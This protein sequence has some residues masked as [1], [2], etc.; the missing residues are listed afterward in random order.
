M[1]GLLGVLA[2]EAARNRAARRKWGVWALASRIARWLPGFTVA[3]A[4]AGVLVRAGI[5]FAAG[6]FQTMGFNGL[7]S[8]SLVF[9]GLGAA[10]GAVAAAFWAVRWFRPVSR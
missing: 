4:L 6:Q 10:A 5:Y 9:A 1:E 2:E 3:G 7:L 8:A